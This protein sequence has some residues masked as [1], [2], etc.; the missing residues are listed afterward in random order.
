MSTNLR[1]GGNLEDL[2]EPLKT[3]YQNLPKMLLFIFK[4]LIGK[5]E[6]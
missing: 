1:I 4:I 3:L 2:T 6:S 5:S